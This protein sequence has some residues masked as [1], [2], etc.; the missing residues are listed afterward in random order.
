MEA[1]TWNE[2]RHVEDGAEAMP[3]N[4]CSTDVGERLSWK[5]RQKEKQALRTTLIQIVVRRCTQLLISL[6]YFFP[7]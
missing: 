3:V 4:S 7:D 2:R 1:L 6:D 5:A